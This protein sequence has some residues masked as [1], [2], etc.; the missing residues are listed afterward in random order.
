MKAGRERRVPLDGRA[1]EGL[2]DAEESRQNELVSL[3]QPEVNERQYPLKA[4]S[5]LR[6]NAVPLRLR[7][8][9]RDWRR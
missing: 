4:A 2:A 7:S 5:C 9:F 1:A 8:S 3:R 6:I